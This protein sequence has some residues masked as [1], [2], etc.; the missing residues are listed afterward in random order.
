MNS[1]YRL[2]S[3]CRDQLA[4]K[5]LI[6]K[7]SVM[8]ILAGPSEMRSIREAAEGV[9]WVGLE[10]S[11]STNSRTR[12]LATAVIQDKKSRRDLAV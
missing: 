3:G 11:C 8:E 5:W 9:G 12:N 7:V 10:G 6:E 4:E 2:P 1:I